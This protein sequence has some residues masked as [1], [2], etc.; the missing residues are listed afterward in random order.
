VRDR[1]LA[2]AFELIESRGLE[3][4]TLDEVAH[5]AGCAVTSVHT[6]FGGRAGLL[7]AL[8]DQYSPIASVER[9]LEKRPQRSDDQVR[10]VYEASYDVAIRRSAVGPALLA[11]ILG[12]PEGPI[13]AI[14]RRTVMPS[15]LEH[16]GGWLV[17]EA[18]KGNCREL[19]PSLAFCRGM[20]LPAGRTS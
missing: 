1:A 12:R 10:A 17:E 15:V 20:E 3:G 7:A 8:F 11:S 4:L 9:V 16:I 5:R 2:A 14:A 18:G 13:G 6:Q 19:P